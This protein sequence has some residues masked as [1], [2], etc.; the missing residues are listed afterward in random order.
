MR[1]Y[2]S[3]GIVLLFVTV[4]CTGIDKYENVTAPISKEKMVDILSDVLIAESLY[5]TSKENV[6]EVGV[7][8]EVKKALL[9]HGVTKEEFDESR[10]IYFKEFRETETLTKLVAE[11]IKEKETLFLESQNS[12]K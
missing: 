11:K 2:L 9:F 3:I 10:K 12:K 4:S 5:D 8:K 7:T 1:I 6:R